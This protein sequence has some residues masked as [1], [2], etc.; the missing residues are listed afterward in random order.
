MNS[1]LLKLQ[2]RLGRGRSVIGLHIGASSVTAVQFAQYKGQ[3]TLIKTAE[4]NI[5]IQKG[6]DSVLVIA[7]ALQAVLSKFSIQKATLICAF[8]DPQVFVKRI[9]TPPMPL[10]ELGAAVQLTV[11][12]DFPFSLEEAFLDFRMINKYSYQGKERYSVLVAA[13]PFEVIERVLD[14]FTIPKKGSVSGS[15]KEEIIKGS[16]SR[17]AR[18][19]VSAIIPGNIGLENLVR[20]FKIKQNETVAIIAMRSNA[21]KLMIYRNSHFEFFRSLSVTSDDITKSMIGDFYS[22]AG[23]TELTSFEA[24]EIKKIYGIPKPDEK[25]PFDVKITSQQI[26]TLI[27]PKIEQLAGDVNRAFDY[28]RQELQG[29]KVDRVLL[30]G[31]GSLLK[32]LDVFLG[33]ELGVEVKIGDPL[34][35]VALL[36]TSLISSNED[37]QVKVFALGAALGSVQDINFL[38]KASAKKPDGNIQLTLSKL[39]VVLTFLVSLCAFV[40]LESQIITQKNKLDLEK[41]RIEVHTKRIREM[42]TL[43]KLKEQRPSWGEILRDLSSIPREIYLTELSLKNDLLSIKGVVFETGDGSHAVLLDFVSAIQKDVAKSANLKM[44]RK[45]KDTTD[46]FS[47]E[48]VAA[49]ESAR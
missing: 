17:P 22:D 24:E 4:E 49:I 48:I 25:I 23:K 29:F 47:F 5:V 20:K 42:L 10:S 12:N 6:K 30:L 44:T 40:F 8:H 7:S 14:Y 38:S 28:Y 36:D 11:K 3:P 35:G 27:G 31:G 46:Q 18:F 16:K 45:V 34:E 32:R 1:S 15:N 9:N 39:A 43:K 13:C 2:E 37:A 41:Q 26:L 33:E 21:T 19:Q